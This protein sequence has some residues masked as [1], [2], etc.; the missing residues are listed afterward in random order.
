MTMIRPKSTGSDAWNM[1]SGPLAKS[2]TEIKADL[3][4]DLGLELSLDGEAVPWSTLGDDAT[5]LSENV[6]EDQD[7]ENQKQT[8][9]WWAQQMALLSNNKDREKAFKP[10]CVGNSDRSVLIRANVPYVKGIYEP[11]VTIE[12]ENDIVNNLEED[13]LCMGKAAAEKDGIVD[14]SYAESLFSVPEL[15]QLCQVCNMLGEEDAGHAHRNDLDGWQSTAGAQGCIHPPKHMKH[16]S[17]EDICISV[18]DLQA[19]TQYC[20]EMGLGK[21]AL[22]EDLGGWHDSCLAEFCNADDDVTGVHQEAKD[23]M[24]N[25]MSVLEDVARVQSDETAEYG[26]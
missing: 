16:S 3:G 9:K 17:G 1:K 19:A 13:G 26:T 18:G 5:G 8:G 6:L 23:S 2:L 10:M 12:L 7:L 4:G 21:E 14:V 24:T 11:V 25:L 20:D 22:G 15:F